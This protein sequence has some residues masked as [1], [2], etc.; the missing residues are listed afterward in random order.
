ME[1]IARAVKAHRAVITTGKTCDVSFRRN[2]LK[3]LKSD[4]FTYEDRTYDAFWKNLCK[5]R[6]EVL[7]AE[8]GI[9]SIEYSNK[10]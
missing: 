8:L 3:K 6:F 5:S 7:G 2:N 4:L 9:V 10:R 1:Y